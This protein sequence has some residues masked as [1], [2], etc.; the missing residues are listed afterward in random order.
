MAISMGLS[1][2]LCM[3]NP[4]IHVV[5]VGFSRPAEWIGARTCAHVQVE[6]CTGILNEED[7]ETPSLATVGSALGLLASAQVRQS[8]RQRVAPAPQ[9]V[10][11]SSDGWCGCRST[12]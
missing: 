9:S 5:V 7:K 10:C 1:L 2:E 3:P 11:C 12:H 8:G 4:T 6:L